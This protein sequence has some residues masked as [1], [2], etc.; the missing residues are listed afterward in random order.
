M[1]KVSS[2]PHQGTSDVRKIHLVARL[3]SPGDWFPLPSSVQNPSACFA[4]EVVQHERSCRVERNTS[5]L[6]RERLLYRAELFM[7]RSSQR[8]MRCHLL[9]VEREI[10][11][12][13]AVRRFVPLARCDMM[14]VHL[15]LLTTLCH[16]P[17]PHLP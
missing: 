3:E 17:S 2:E 16:V 15:L 9:T 1:L 4:A 8:P 7:M 6:L 10:V 13:R 11:L 5:Q 14:C 12:D